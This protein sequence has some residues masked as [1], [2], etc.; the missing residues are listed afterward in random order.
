MRRDDARQLPGG[1]SR[2]GWDVP[3]AVATSA[4]AAAARQHPVLLA[5]RRAAL[6]AG[7][8]A[9][10][11]AIT[12]FAQT[13]TGPGGPRGRGAQVEL[14]Q[15]ASQLLSFESKLNHDKGR[16]N[17]VIHRLGEIKT[18]EAQIRKEQAALLAKERATR[19]TVHRA[20]NKVVSLKY[21]IHNI[22]Q[23]AFSN[24]LFDGPK[25]AEAKKAQAHDNLR[26][27]ARELKTQRAQFET[28]V[29]KVQREL[30]DAS[31]RPAAQV[32][33]ALH[34]AQATKNAGIVAGGLRQT[35]KQISAMQQQAAAKARAAA[36]LQKKKDAD[37]QKALELE[38]EQKVARERP[39]V[40]QVVRRAEGK[41]AHAGHV[42]QMQA[43]VL[44]KRMTSFTRPKN[45]AGSWMQGRVALTPAAK[46]TRRLSDAYSGK[47]SEV[48]A[49]NPVTLEEASALASKRAVLA[50]RQA[51]MRSP[52]YWQSQQA[53]TTM[54]RFGMMPGLPLLRPLDRAAADI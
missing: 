23:D 18:A 24:A 44:R 16:L 47:A 33:T 13:Q 20:R 48:Q 7:S 25:A 40:Q 35:Q 34:T 26:R 4:A 52:Q 21:K 10:V 9:L 11:L 12:A 6:L 37:M 38:R 53:A 2:R 50:Q 31:T 45:A 32:A 49:K 46:Q 51:Y 41:H 39:I 30:H 5:G 28:I 15:A 54:K 3:A 22:K 27:K 42:A 17:T 8:V 1:S 19:A 36:A 29:G 43:Q 14:A